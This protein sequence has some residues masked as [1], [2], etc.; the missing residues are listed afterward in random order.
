MRET[1]I[2]DKGEGKR[3]KRM[4]DD[5]LTK[6]EKLKDAYKILESDKDSIVLLAAITQR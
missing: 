3:L 4:H 6:L 5:I 1:P 2:K